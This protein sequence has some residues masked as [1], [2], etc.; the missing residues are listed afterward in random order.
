MLVSRAKLYLKSKSVLLDINRTID[1]LDIR[2]KF[3]SGTKGRL[4]INI[5]FYI[6]SKMANKNYRKG[7]YLKR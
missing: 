2:G 7:G 5:Y 6:K 4:M 1:G 3:I